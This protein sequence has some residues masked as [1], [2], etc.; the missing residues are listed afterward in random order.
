MRVNMYGIHGGSREGSEEALH[1]QLQILPDV[2]LVAQEH[3]RAVGCLVTGG[4]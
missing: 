4:L 3:F 2:P 1:Y